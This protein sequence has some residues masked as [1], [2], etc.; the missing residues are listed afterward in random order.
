MKIK[1]I[2]QPQFNSATQQ[3]LFNR[4]I[5]ITDIQHYLNTTDEDVSDPELFG[6]ETLKQAAAILVKCI[7]RGGKILI[8]VDSD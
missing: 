1:L 6:E 5:D 4:G 3:V 7:K 8:I 2:S